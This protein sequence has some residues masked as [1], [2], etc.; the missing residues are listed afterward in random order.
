M[1][2]S[3]TEETDDAKVRA[4]ISCLTILETVRNT[5]STDEKVKTKM[6]KVGSQLGKQIALASFLGYRVGK[7]VL[8]K[9]KQKYSKGRRK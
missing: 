7:N 4:M 5:N 9:L 8:S 3:T 6:V 1:E 2:T